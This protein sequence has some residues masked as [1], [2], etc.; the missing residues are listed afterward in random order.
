MTTMDD[1]DISAVHRAHAEAH[2]ER[3]RPPAPGLQS[4]L[5]DG[6]AA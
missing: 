2:P 3:L 5:S 1:T 6:D 4:A